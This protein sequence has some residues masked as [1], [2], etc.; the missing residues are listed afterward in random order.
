MK[1]KPTISIV[2]ISCCK[3]EYRLNLL[4][5]TI[6]SLRESTKSRY[7][8]IVADNGNKKQTE[9]LKSIRPSKHLIFGSNMGITYGRNTGAENATGDYICFVDSDVVFQR[10]WGR[11]LINV[12][13]KKDK[14]I[15]TGIY[16]SVMRF[17]KWRCKHKDY[18]Y[19]IWSRAPGTCL[20][21]SR[22]TWDDVKPWPDTWRMGFDFCTQAARKGYSFVVPI[23]APAAHLDDRPSYNKRLLAKSYNKG[24][25]KWTMIK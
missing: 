12:L 17:N 6:K 13:K 3:S 15:A 9:Y 14:L 25:P 18:D 2:M 8:L 4:K 19:Q 7:E 24:K 1:E 21:M 22:Q 16:G 20:L 5:M 10:R 23:P 11:Q